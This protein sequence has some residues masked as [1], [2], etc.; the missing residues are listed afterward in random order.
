MLQPRFTSNSRSLLPLYFAAFVGAAGLS[1]C[2]SGAERHQANFNED[3]N[4]CRSFGADYGS[5]AYSECMLTQQHRRDA[6][7]RESLER[8]QMTSDI[9]R[10]GQIMADRA[11]KQRCDRDPNRKECRK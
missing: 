9:A 8:T 7:H 2:M 10:D 11:R 3:A 1:G 5:A 4:T 6:K